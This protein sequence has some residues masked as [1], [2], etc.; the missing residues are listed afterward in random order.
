MKGS[1]TTVPKRSWPVVVTSRRQKA[2]LSHEGTDRRA[3]MHEF[4][5]GNI[6][7]IGVSSVNTLKSAPNIEMVLKSRGWAK[8]HARRSILTILGF[9][10][11]RVGAEQP[12]L[13]RYPLG[14]VG[15]PR[16][17]YR[18]FSPATF[19]HSLGEKVRIVEIQIVRACSVVCS[20][21]RDLPVFPIERRHSQRKWRSCSETIISL[22]S[23]VMSMP[24]GLMMFMQ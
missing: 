22:F 18:Q 11:G 6:N 15:P 4:D 16:G 1:V 19:L 23:K 17:N 10:C 9:C 14:Q 21:D 13:L 8:Q 20:K 2:V 7:D 5:P 24:T 3:C 12:I